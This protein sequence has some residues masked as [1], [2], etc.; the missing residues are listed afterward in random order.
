MLYSRNRLL[1]ISNVV[2]SSFATQIYKEFVFDLTVVS[3]CLI[4][5]HAEGDVCYEKTKDETA[6][7]ISTGLFPF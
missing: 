7:G 5:V 2:L 6:F 4:R 1:E 3:Q